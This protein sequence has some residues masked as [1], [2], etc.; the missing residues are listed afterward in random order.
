MSPRG[1]AASPARCP[2]KPDFRSAPAA[3]TPSPVSFE[4]VISVSGRYPRT[5][6]ALASSEIAFAIA[7]KYLAQAGLKRTN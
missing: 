7:P 4:Q 2:S 6:T 1:A 5:N 3:R